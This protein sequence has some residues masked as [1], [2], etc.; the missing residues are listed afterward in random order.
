MPY[1]EVSTA[2][3]SATVGTNLLSGQDWFKTSGGWRKI[4][5]CALVGSTN[6]GDTQIEI[7]AGSVK[8][9]QVYNS[10]G[11]A[12]MNVDYKRD[13]RMLRT[14]SWIPPGTPITAK[15]LVAPTTNAIIL[16]ME[17]QEMP[18]GWTPFGRRARAGYRG[19]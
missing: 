1:I 9:A 7:D 4:L 15:V 6:P 3:A 18:P 5:S 2:A 19:M 16:A 14:S 10:Y 13:M 17:I 11:G 12:N 8:I